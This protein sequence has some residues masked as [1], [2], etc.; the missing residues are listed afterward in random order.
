GDMMAHWTNNR[1]VSTLHRVV[2]PEN[3]LDVP[4]PA[5]QSI[6]YFMNPNYDAEIKTIPTCVKDGNT[7]KYAPVLAGK[8]LMNKFNSSL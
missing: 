5:R 7:S 3:I 4:S 6:A 1:W 8:Y 2:E